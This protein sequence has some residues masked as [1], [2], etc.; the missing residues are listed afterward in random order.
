[1]IVTLHGLSTMHCDCETEMRIARETGYDA[2]GIVKAKLIRFL[3]QRY[4]PDQ[5]VKL[6]RKIQD[7]AY[8]DKRPEMD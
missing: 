1:M 7:Q 6:M 5:L 8:H 2:W 3:D 4:R